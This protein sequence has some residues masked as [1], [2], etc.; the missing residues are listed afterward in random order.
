MTASQR[1]GLRRSQ[2]PPPPPPPPPPLPLDAGRGVVVAVFV[3]AAAAATLL[4]VLVAGGRTAWAE[5]APCASSDS[6]VPVPIPAPDCVEAEARRLLAEEKPRDAIDLLRQLAGDQASPTVALLMAKA[7][8]ALGNDFW[9]LR[10]IAKAVERKPA[11]CQERLWLAWIHLRQRAFDPARDAVASAVCSTGAEQTRQQLLAAMIEIYAGETAA[12]KPAFAKALAAPESFPEDQRAMAQLRR[13]VDPDHRPLFSGRIELGTGWTS[14]AVASSPT[15]EESAGRDSATPT[16]QL[17]AQAK[18]ALPEY[19][20]FRG[21]LDGETRVLGFSAESGRDHSYLHLSARPALLYRTRLVELLLGYRLEGLALA[22][23]DN[24]EAGPIW[25]SN[26]Q[27]LELEATRGLLVAFAGAGQRSL[28]EAGRSR[29]EIDGGVGGRWRSGR[30]GLLAALT[31]RHHDALRPAYDLWGGSALVAGEMRLARSL[32]ARVS[33][34]LGLDA[35]PEWSGSSPPAGGAGDRRD[36]Q[37]KVALGSYYLSARGVRLGAAYE[38]SHRNSSIA[39]YGFTDHRLLV[40]LTVPFSWE[41]RGPRQVAPPGHVALDYGIDGGEGVME[42]RVQELL[43]QDDS[44]R[45]GSSC[46]E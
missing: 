31:L 28:R 18:L 29:S 16:L 10:E 15:D 34:L 8:L 24:Y 38:M 30:I 46:V 44:V 22:G 33:V 5:A 21:A 35:Y 4:A 43:R 40:K 9:A 23:G 39:G 12:G 27:R 41:G 19:R 25:Y 2:S 37:L 20:G 3:A 26:G 17:D 42:E 32:A 11:S 36:L 13:I 45:R 6:A 14:N 7:Y 1:C